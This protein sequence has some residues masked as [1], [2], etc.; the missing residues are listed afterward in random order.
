[1][2]SGI[3]RTKNALEAGATRFHNYDEWLRIGTVVGEMLAPAPA[4]DTPS[5]FAPR[6]DPDDQPA[7]GVNAS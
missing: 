6:K 4:V 5:P 1:M 3:D 7:T 2:I